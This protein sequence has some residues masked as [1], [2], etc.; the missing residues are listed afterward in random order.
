MSA[1]KEELPHEEG[2]SDTKGNDE[3]DKPDSSKMKKSAEKCVK[4]K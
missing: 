2:D 4:E 3:N 1:I